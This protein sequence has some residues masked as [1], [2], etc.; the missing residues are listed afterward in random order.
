MTW[1]VPED[2]LRAY[3]DGRITD[4]DAWS[5]EAHVASCERCRSAVAQTMVANPEHAAELA[6]S[7]VSITANLPEQGRVRRGSVARRYTVLLASGPAAR[8]AW[9]VA[10]VVVLALSAGLD[11]LTPSPGLFGSPVAILPL[12]APVLP[13]LG[14]AASYG[15]GLDDTYEVIAST[16]GG[17]VRLALVR[18]LAVLAVTIPA[19][20]I[21]G[22]TTD[23]GWSVVWLLPCLAL[24][25]LTLAIGSVIGIGRSAALLGTGWVV[26][27]SAQAMADKSVTIA[28]PSV[29]L[30]TSTAMPGWLV[31]LGLAVAAIAIRREAFNHLSLSTRPL[32]EV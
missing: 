7:W 21:S 31:L 29:P 26:I 25:S 18:T 10:I 13:V 32:R 3:V 11:Q 2:T 15:S 4:A 20:L 27:V 17:G 30:L 6:R 28:D 12:V 9:L 16:P 8:W 5:V 1:H 24:T 19:T 22:L 14:V 23:L